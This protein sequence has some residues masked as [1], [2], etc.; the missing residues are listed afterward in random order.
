MR[1]PNT[2]STLI[3]NTDRFTVP[4][5]DEP[6]REPPPGAELSGFLV[7]AF[8]ARQ[9]N[10]SRPYADECFYVVDVDIGGR[11]YSIRV[12]WEVHGPNPGKE[13]WTINID[14]RLGCLGSI[15]SQFVSRRTD[16]EACIAMV[17]E[18]HGERA[19]GGDARW[20]TDDEL[21]RLQDGERVRRIR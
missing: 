16:L 4:V 3:V 15:I 2:R 9:T 11:A 7:E 13:V 20:V 21:R 5:P 18:I 1:R 17:K 12:Q 6:D 14:E 10:V 8:R 19:L